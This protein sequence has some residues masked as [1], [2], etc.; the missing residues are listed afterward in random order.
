[1]RQAVIELRPYF[2]RSAWFSVFSCLLILA[3]SAYML[4]VY[5]RVVNSR[6]HTTLMMLTLVVLGAFVL[7]EVLEWARSEIL[8]GAGLELDKQMRDRVFDVIFQANLKKIAGGSAQP[9]NDFRTIVYC[10]QYAIMRLHF[11]QRI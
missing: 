11:V 2:V 4:E 9:L 1:M 3:P 6:S 8:H 5:E 10:K 7:M